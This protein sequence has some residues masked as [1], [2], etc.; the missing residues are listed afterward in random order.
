MYLESTDHYEGEPVLVVAGFE[1]DESDDKYL[2]ADAVL[3]HPHLLDDI[4]VLKGENRQ[5]FRVRLKENMIKLAQ[6]K[7]FH[8]VMLK[9]ENIETI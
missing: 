1:I 3:V 7:L 9:R 8:M 5:T 2:Y 4:Y 6:P